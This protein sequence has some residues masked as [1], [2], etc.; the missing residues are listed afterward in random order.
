MT[1]LKWTRR[2]TAK[3]ASE[4]QL[5]GIEVSANTVARLLK[6]MGFSLR[7]N[8][9]KKSN[10]SPKNRDAQFVHIGDL[11]QQFTSVENPIISVDAKKREQVGEFKNPGKSW[12]QEA[13]EVNDHDYRSLAS[14]VGIPYGIYDMQ[15]NCG[16]VFV[17][18]SY[19]TSE[20]A[21]D[22]IKKW[23]RNEG[24]KRYANARELLILADFLPDDLLGQFRPVG[25][26]DPGYILPWN[27]FLL[28]GQ[29]HSQMLLSR[30][31][32]RW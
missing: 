26:R 12:E 7:V 20:F 18:T 4:L 32:V 22:S 21:V 13:V 9:K 3:I 19:D 29:D 25:Y 8:H 17:G 16:T 28:V 23:W 31:A 6:D 27:G 2:T 10:G 5:Q 15:E 1:G 24:A 14:G 11:Q 30:L